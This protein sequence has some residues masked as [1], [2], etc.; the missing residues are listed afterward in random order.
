MFKRMGFVALVVLLNTSQ[1]Y[2]APVR[3]HQWEGMLN[4]SGIGPQDDALSGAAYVGVAANYGLTDYLALGVQVGWAQV[5]VD[6]AVAQGANPAKAARINYVPIYLNIMA[7][8][9]DLHKFFVP[10]GMIGVGAAIIAID[11]ESGFSSSVNA[12]SAAAFKI[13]GG[14]DYFLDWYPEWAINF[15]FSYHMIPKDVESVS[16]S[17]PVVDDANLDFW[18]FGVNI[19]YVF[20]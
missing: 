6:L 5:D 7:R 18:L 17:G 10:Y 12:D 8:T 19:K 9:P 15:D 4:I 20:D 14:F 11:K 2:S 3:T 1:A 16:S 13:G